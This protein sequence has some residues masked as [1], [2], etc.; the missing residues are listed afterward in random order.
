[1]NIHATSF[2]VVLLLAVLC[3]VGWTYARI[4]R[5]VFRTQGYSITVPLTLAV[6]ICALSFM[7]VGL[8]GLLILLALVPA[9]IFERRRSRDCA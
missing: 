2:V 7:W 6:L 4:C 5:A 9:W 1:M 8:S 3:A